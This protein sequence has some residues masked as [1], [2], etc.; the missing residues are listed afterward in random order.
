MEIGHI[1]VKRDAI[2][3]AAAAPRSIPLQVAP[4]AD[5]ERPRIGT[6]L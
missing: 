4:A 3:D 6:A 1:P 2:G 5:D